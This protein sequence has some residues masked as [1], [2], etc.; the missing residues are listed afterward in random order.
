MDRGKVPVPHPPFHIHPPPKDPGRSL[1][2]SLKTLTFRE[3]IPPITCPQLES[4]AT[5]SCP[6]DNRQMQILAEEGY[7]LI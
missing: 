1:E 7:N 5:S 6:E 4:H 2:D 3:Y